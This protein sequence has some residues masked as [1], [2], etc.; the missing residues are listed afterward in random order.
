MIRIFLLCL[1]LWLN[2]PSEGKKDAQRIAW[3][4]SWNDEEATSVAHDL[5][6]TFPADTLALLADCVDNEGTLVAC[7]SPAELRRLALRPS[8]YKTRS[9]TPT[10][11]LMSDGCIHMRR[12]VARNGR[13]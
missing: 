7:L 6:D 9:G 4:I 2:V 3:M 5:E 10:S 12:H 13:H 11:S 8:V 1:P